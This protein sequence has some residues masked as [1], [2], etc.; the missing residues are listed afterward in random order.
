[1]E[2]DRGFF[3]ETLNKYMDFTPVQANMSKSSKGVV[4]GLHYQLNTA[5]LVW[6]AKGSI[7]D[8][9]V[10]PET[11]EVA[12]VELSADNHKQLLVPANFL[13]GFQAL[14]DDTIVCY[15]MDRH[16][17]Q[18]TEGGYNPS[19]IDWP[20]EPIMSEKDKN[21]DKLYS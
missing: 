18:K 16:Y 12:K 14:E 10:D 2:D 6:V 21:A 8:V 20:L 3:T 19:Y 7:L 5:K 4:R 17:N 13:H 9:A 15:L 11:G 1:Y